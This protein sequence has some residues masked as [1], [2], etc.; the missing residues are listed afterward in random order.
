MQDV[1]NL[2]IRLKHLED[3]VLK[4]KN[5]RIPKDVRMLEIIKNYGGKI[6][7]RELSNRT[8]FVSLVERNEIISSLERSGKIATEKEKRISGQTVHFITAL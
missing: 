7:K 5:V 2:E 3:I 4:K 1:K 8:R 6:P